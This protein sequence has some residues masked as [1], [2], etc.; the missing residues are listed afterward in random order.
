MLVSSF[1]HYD[2]LE[3]DHEHPVQ[4]QPKLEVSVVAG[5]FATRHS[6]NT[7][8]IDITRMKHEHTMPVRPP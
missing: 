5:H 3:R 2:E 1:G 4:V 8:Y 7:H 6:H